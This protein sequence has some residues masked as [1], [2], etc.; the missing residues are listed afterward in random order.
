VRLPAA[1]EE[2]FA[3]WLGAV[4]DPGPLRFPEV[5]RGVQALSARYVERRGRP[6]GIGSLD[7]AGVR[8]A[9]VSYYAPLHFLAAH[10][11]AAALPRPWLAG[12]RRVVDV[13]AGTGAVGAALSLV[14]GDAPVLALDRA[15]WALSEAR[16]SFALLGVPGRTRAASLPGGLPRLGADDLVTAGWVLNELPAEV[17]ERVV[18]AF[19]RALAAGARLLVLEPLARAIAPWWTDLAAR[20]A[21][22]GVVATEFKW[23]IERPAWIEKLDVASGLDHREI[24]ARVLWGPTGVAGAPE[25]AP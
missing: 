3:A 24:G 10:H 20:L 18:R 15:G 5:R 12:V 1:R 2:R 4:S 11:T 7:G 21:G 16:R 25:E 6:A 14:A 8:A 17:R 9:F 23:P 19:E 22:L 13:G